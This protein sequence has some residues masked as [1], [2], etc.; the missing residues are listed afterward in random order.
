MFREFNN[1]SSSDDAASAALACLTLTLELI[2]ALYHE[3]VLSGDKCRRI[4]EYSMTNFSGLEAQA[5][6]E[7]D[8]AIFEKAQLLLDSFLTQ[9]FGAPTAAANVRQ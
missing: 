2:T 3:G 4:V 6:N 8:R 7:A 1:M 9:E 5:A